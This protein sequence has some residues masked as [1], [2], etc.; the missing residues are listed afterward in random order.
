MKAPSFVSLSVTRELN[1]EQSVL[2]SELILK[3]EKVRCVSGSRSEP[4]SSGIASDGHVQPP[5]S[6][7]ALPGAPGVGLED[8]GRFR[9]NA[10]Y[11]WMAF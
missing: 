5:G 6:H 2:L 9:V 4:G 8:S 11:S 10:P 1:V 3:A 7:F